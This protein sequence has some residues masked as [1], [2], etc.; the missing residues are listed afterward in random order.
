M[1][2]CKSEKKGTLV[3]K[4]ISFLSDS[5]KSYRS[6]PTHQTLCVLTVYVIIKDLSI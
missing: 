5:D 1:D 2:V 6:C 4:A 3:C